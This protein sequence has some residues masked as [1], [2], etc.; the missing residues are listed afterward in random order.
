[1]KMKNE[2]SPSQEE[3]LKGKLKSLIR[4]IKVD[5]DP[6]ELN[7]YRKIIRRNVPLHLR[8][9]LA[10]LL[11]KQTNGGSLSGAEAQTQMQ[12]IF[13]SIGK[14]RR[15]FPRDLAR[16]FNK[17]L[18][19]A[20]R[21]LGN[22]KVLDNYSFIDVPREKASEAIDKLNGTDFRGRN[23]TVNFARKKK[24]SNDQKTR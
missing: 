18:D 5:E 14:N 15:V 24:P 21:Q 23:I 9:Y 8:S 3:I 13:V 7:R 16:L 12:T 11:L 4:Q 1:M 17:T 19:L 22:I 10:A 6:D 20:P 2:N